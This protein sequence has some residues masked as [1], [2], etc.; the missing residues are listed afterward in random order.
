[1]VGLDCQAFSAQQ[2]KLESIFSTR[3]GAADSKIVPVLANLAIKSSERKK[4]YAQQ[5]I[6]TCEDF[7]KVFLLYFFSIV[8]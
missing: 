3:E 8:V 2:Q 7:V 1:M 4:G 6:K 5:L